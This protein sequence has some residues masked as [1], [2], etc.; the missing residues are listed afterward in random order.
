MLFDKYVGVVGTGLVPPP[1]VKKDWVIVQLVFSLLPT[2]YRWILAVC[3]IRSAP[4]HAPH[5]AIMDLSSMPACVPRMT[6]HLS[7]SR[8]PHFPH[9]NHGPGSSS[10]LAFPK[11]CDRRT[12]GLLPRLFFPCGTLCI[13][14]RLLPRTAARMAAD[15]GSEID[16]IVS[17][18]G[19]QGHGAFWVGGGCYFS[20]FR[21]TAIRLFHSFRHATVVR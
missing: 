9:R 8:L 18:S 15:R 6:H 14:P 4:H 7:F 3:P 19:G 13:C 2:C 21:V 20:P 10:S 17:D 12:G 5:H 16:D 1:V 11:L